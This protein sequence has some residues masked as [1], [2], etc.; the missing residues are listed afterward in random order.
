MQILQGNF[1]LRFSRLPSLELLPVLSL[2]SLDLLP[3]FPP[4]RLLCPFFLFPP[5]G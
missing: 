2:L 1:T 3:F 5:G 4:L